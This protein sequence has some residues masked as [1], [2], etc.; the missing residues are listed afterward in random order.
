MQDM[1]VEHVNDRY[2]KYINI[3]IRPSHSDQY[4]LK[5]FS[6]MG[7]E[8]TTRKMPLSFIHFLL[9]LLC[10][11]VGQETSYGA[12]VISKGNEAVAAASSRAGQ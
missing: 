10:M 4:A 7:F 9:F 3:F 11:P 8:A 2:S 12:E 5:E 1:A 6:V